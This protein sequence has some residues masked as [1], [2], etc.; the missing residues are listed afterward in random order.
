MASLRGA[1]LATRAQGAALDVLALGLCGA[2]AG[3]LFAAPRLCLGLGLAA[4]AVVALR[5]TEL[6]AARAIQRGRP[7]LGSALEA[8][9]EGQG[10]S[11]RAQL[12][13]WVAARTGPVFLWREAAL[14]AAAGLLALAAQTPRSA[15]LIAAAGGPARLEVRARVEPPTYTGWPAQEVSGAEVRALR[16]SRVQLFGNALRVA[17]AEQSEQ[18]FHQPLEVK[19]QRSTT[20][21]FS[22]GPL[23]QLVQL[24]ALQDK[25]PE[26]TLLSPEADRTV[27]S[28]PAPFQVRARATDDVAVASLTLHYTLAQGRGEGMKFRNGR[29][30]SSGLG[31]ASALLDPRALGMRQGDTLVVWAEATDGNAVDG[32][33]RGRS[34]ARLLR[35]EEAVVDLSGLHAGVTVPPPKSLLTE[36]ELLA[37]TQRLVQS[38][39]KGAVRRTRSAELAGDQRSLRVSF[40]FFLQAEQGAGAALDVDDKELAESGDARARKLLAQAVAAMWEAESELS[41]NNPAGAIPHERAAVKALDAAFGLVRLALRPGAAPD[42]PVDESRRLKGEQ[43]GL[44]PLAPPAQRPERPEAARV[45][46]LARAL[47]LASQAAQLDARA[48]GDS[49]WALPAEVGAA[50]LATALY[51]ARDTAERS[52][53]AR[54]AGEGLS[55]WLRPSPVAVPPVASGSSELLDRVPLLP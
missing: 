32:P 13:A 49:L 8:W 19:L 15:A 50:G 31:E 23:V 41:V 40:G 26:V 52:A 11:L 18:A 30:P 28:A 10:G 33:G 21:R 36:R 9:L 1:L 51:A 34:D 27:K 47:F 3:A 25:P 12:S 20:L 16:G 38:G 35:W 22:R 37:R 24:Q 39:A 5:W 4:G 17:E 29:L 42:K 53:A 43:K 55:R 46:E 45:A 7:A 6:R 14:A 54:T 44:R 48:L 2:A